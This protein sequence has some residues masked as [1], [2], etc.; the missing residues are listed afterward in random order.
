MVKLWAWLAEFAFRRAGFRVVR[1]DKDR[2]T[3]R[4]VVLLSNDGRPDHA[5][6]DAVRVPR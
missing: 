5:P 1:I 3:G 4:I 6:L 2:R